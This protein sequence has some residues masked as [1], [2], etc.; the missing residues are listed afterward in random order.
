MKQIAL[1]V[2]LLSPFLAISQIRPW[3]DSDEPAARNRV[4]APSEYRT[5]LMDMELLGNFLR[6]VPDESETR[7]AESQAILELPMPDGSVL[8]FGIVEASIM[9]PALQQ[10]YPQIRSYA[11]QG[12]EDPSTILRFSFSHRGFNGLILR[13]A[14][15]IYIDPYN[16]GETD[17]YISYTKD[18]FYATTDKVFDEIPPLLGKDYQ[19]VPEERLERNPAQK[20]KKPLWKAAA[21]GGAR[22]SNGEDLRIY[23]LALACTGEYAT[24]HGGTV[25]DALAAMNVSMTRINGVYERDVAIRMVLVADN[26]DIIFLNG[27][28]D[29]YTNNNGGAMLGQNQTTCDNIIGS[30]NYDIGHVFS[31]GG[32]GVAYLNAP[33][34]NAIKAGGVTGSG[35]P[36][37]DPFDI[38]YVAHEM[39]HQCGANHTQNNNCNRVASAAYEPGSASTIMG[40]AGI[41]VPNIQ[42]NSDDHFHNRSFNEMLGYMVNG[43]GNVC[44]TIQGTGNTPP[45][46]DAGTGD[47]FIPIGTPFELTATAFDPDGDALTYNWEQYNL[48]PATAAG[49]NLLQNPSGNAPIF[50]S[51]PSSNSPTRVFPR[52]SDLVNNT[53]VIGELLPTYTRAMDFK[54]TVRDNRAGGGGVT[55]D[56]ISFDATADAGPFVVTAPN[57][58]VTYPG[59]SLQ[60]VTWD[61]A[62]TDAAPVNCDDVDIFLSTDGGYTF[63]T[64]LLA[65]TPNDGSA[66]VL[67]PAGET[68]S[69]R[70]KVKGGNNIFFDIS[71]VNFTIGPSIGDNSDDAAISA[72]NEPEGDYCGDEVT[73]EVV[74]SNFGSN[75]IT[76]FTLSYN[77]DGGPDESYLWNGNLLSGQTVAILLPLAVLSDGNHTFNVTVSEPNGVEDTNN[78]N[79]SGSSSFS[80]NSSPNF[81]TINVFTDCYGEETGWTLED[82]NNVVIASVA[83]GTLA[84][85][86]NYS[87][88]Y[89]VSNGCYDITFTDT[90][91]DGMEA[92]NYGCVSDGSYQLLDQDNNIL[93]EIPANPNFGSSISQN[94]CLPFGA[95]FG[96]TDPIACNFDPAANVNDG[97]CTYGPDGDACSNALAIVP[98]GNA[99]N[100]SNV[101]TCIDGPNPTCGGAGGIRDIWFSFVYGGGD[102][103]IETTLGTLT[104]TRIALFGS[105]G[106]AQIT[107]ND[108]IGGGNLASRI[109]RTCAQLTLGQTYYI[110]AG[111]YNAQ[112]GSFSISISVSGVLGCTDP[113]ACNY[114]P[115]ATC[116]DESCIFSNFTWY[117][118]NDNDG[119]GDVNDAVIACNPPAGFVGDN[120]DCNDANGSVFPGAFEFCDGLDNNC[121]G[122]IDEGAL[123]AFYED[124]DEDGF[125][126]ALVSIQACSAP[127]GYVEDNSDCDDNNDAAFPGAPGTASGI[128]NNCNG[129]ID[130]Q[131]QLPD[132]CSGDF[133]D[134]GSVN[135]GDLLI[136]LGEYGCAENCFTD[137]DGDNS[138]STNDLLIFFTQYGDDCP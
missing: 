133:N 82:E 14:E 127:A 70:I 69:A 79:D 86:T 91:G 31:T 51:W 105:C 23:A 11:G 36:V 38:D 16:F 57:T 123:L 99:V 124:S 9:D 93:A 26:D 27:G 13:P 28:T 110:Q 108:D 121:D 132:P 83:A 21:Q 94:F 95:V 85:L 87:W 116:N 138:I 62:N 75:D 50:R 119:F 101:G 97:S 48:G 8:S 56:L 22:A 7:A 137:L 78:T 32:G 41:C 111:G 39:G 135:V 34:N 129:T 67:I 90:Y 118:D 77:F 44:A 6:E 52:I 120:T 58:A 3:G 33:C 4:I 73:P 112:T 122:N 30:A 109:L 134:D 71:N 128:D 115:D 19:V 106:G 37:G 24:Y 43:G 17:Y 35:N 72:I 113:S 68:N 100:A 88:S 81:V 66:L 55:D 53:T 136:L 61:V 12:I 49:D 5:V 117:A 1:F 29:P 89:C 107:C 76:S 40:Y 15:T 74:V 47:F 45:T 64:L 102:I 2:A 96:C 104:D 130:P 63:P 25:P 20:E 46:V 125:G 59:N 126:N 84:S 42:N 131:E 98:G 18:A 103:T 80:T 10:R 54:C 65:G 114:D 60:T 92:T